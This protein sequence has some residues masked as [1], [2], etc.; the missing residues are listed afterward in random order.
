MGFWSLH[1]CL[2]YTCHHFERLEDCPLGL[3][4]DVYHN[5]TLSILCFGSA[6]FWLFISWSTVQQH[7]TSLCL[8]NKFVRF[9]GKWFHKPTKCHR[10]GV[11]EEYWLTVKGNAGLTDLSK[12]YC[13]G[14][15]TD[16]VASCFAWPCFGTLWGMIFENLVAS[17]KQF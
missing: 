2:F 1:W 17:L 14:F 8:P 12:I 7:S 10:G 11:A 6:S 9:W 15:Q 16:W 3:V 4:I 13:K 5:I